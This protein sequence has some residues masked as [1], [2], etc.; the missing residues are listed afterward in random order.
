M[1]ELKVNSGTL[2]EGI[3]P[4]GEFNPNLYLCPLGYLNC[5]VGD[6]EANLLPLVDSGLQLNLIS[7]SLANKLKLTPRI[8]FSS[9]VYGI[10]N[11]AC[12][13]IGVA[14]DVPI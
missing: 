9:A 13:L 1:E 4:E 14:E 12:E 8:N 5:F 2:V 6:G 11:Q 7:N 3:N 10:N